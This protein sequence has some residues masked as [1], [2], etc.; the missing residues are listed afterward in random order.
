MQ[1]A[2][3]GLRAIRVVR[4]DAAALREIVEDLHLAES[5]PAGDLDAGDDLA[6]AGRSDL[7][8]PQVQRAACARRQRYRRLLEYPA[9]E[10]V[11]DKGNVAVPFIR[12]ECRQPR[13][14]DRVMPVTPKWTSAAPA[15]ITNIKPRQTDALLSVCSC[16]S[17]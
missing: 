1:L 8:C 6:A 16:V 17:S 2:G 4:H 12:T 15:G 14:L 3:P 11:K 10:I 5:A 7:R 9:G 13:C